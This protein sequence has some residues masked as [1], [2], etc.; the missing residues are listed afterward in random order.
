SSTMHEAGHSFYALSQD[1]GDR[2]GLPTTGTPSLAIHESQSRTWENIVGRSREFWIYCFPQLQ[3]MFPKQTRGVR[4][5]DI[6]GAVNYVT[7]SYIRVDA[8]E[9]TYNLHIMLRFEMERAVISGELPVKDVAGEW[10]RRFKDYFGLE[11]DNDANGCLQD[12]HWSDGSFGYFPTYA[13]GNLYAAQFWM[14]AQKDLPGIKDDFAVGRF[15]RLMTW[16]SENIHQKGSTYL[17]NDLCQ[18][19]TGAPLSHQPL[20]DYLYEKY[21]D[22]YGISRP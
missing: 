17:P 15:S 12:T 18:R 7:P 20:L 4:A 21:E 9:A 8:D 2:W 14:Q 22:I 11:V 6:Y 5:E 13:L 10:N 3:G 1:M 19:L 16:L